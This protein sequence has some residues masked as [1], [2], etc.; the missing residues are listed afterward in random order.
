MYSPAYAEDAPRSYGAAASPSPAAAVGRHRT[1][2][3]DAPAFDPLLWKNTDNSYIATLATHAMMHQPAPAPSYAPATA[4]QKS[5]KPP[6]KSFLSS[7]WAQPPGE[8]A[9]ARLS[10]FHN[11]YNRRPT[12]WVGRVLQYISATFFSRWH[13]EVRPEDV[14]ALSTTDLIH[15]MQLALA[16]GEVDRSAM[17]ARELSRRKLALQMQP[18]S[19]NRSDPITSTGAARE[20]WPSAP[21]PPA[22]PLPQPVSATR[23]TNDGAFLPRREQPHPPPMPPPQP[24]GPFSSLYDLP[25]NRDA[26]WSQQ[27]KSD[28]P[29]QPLP[30]PSPPPPP[31]P[32]PRPVYEPQHHYHQQP[33]PQPQRPMRETSERR[34]RPVSVERTSAWTGEESRSQP[35][36]ALQTPVMHTRGTEAVEFGSDIDLSS[37]RASGSGP[38][39]RSDMSWS[40]NWVPARF[41]SPF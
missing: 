9:A 17:L 15:L 7:S 3:D 8:A 22:S 28:Y 33:Q 13:E 36:H 18:Y 29:A 6:L 41:Q 14:A 25:P 5:A 12:S 1:P 19:A 31:P 39:R 20:T 26:P 2:R 24:T 37:V 23:Y 4:S 40:D 21:P 30:R 16:A 35:P 10:R 11:V 27:Q 38:A 34:S 32:Q